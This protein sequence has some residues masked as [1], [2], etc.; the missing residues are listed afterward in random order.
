VKA[1]RNLSPEKRNALVFLL[2]FLLG[3]IATL[4]SLRPQTSYVTELWEQMHGEQG[5]SHKIAFSP[6]GE[7]L[8]T[9]AQTVKVWRAKD[10]K[11]VKSFPFN[12]P[13]AV[14]TLAPNGKWLAAYDVNGTVKVWKLP[15]GKIVKSLKADRG[16]S[17]FLAFSPDGEFLA[18]AS[19]ELGVVKVWRVESGELVKSLSLGANR[20]V[21]MAVSPGGEFLAVMTFRSLNLDDRL[22]L[23]HLPATKKISIIRAPIS[24]FSFSPDG[25]FLTSVGVGSE[26]YVVALRKVGDEE[27]CWKICFPNEVTMVKFHPCDSSILFVYE[28]TS[29]DLLAPLRPQPFTTPA[30]WV[31]GDV[32]SYWRLTKGGLEKLW[33][34]RNLVSKPLSF[35]DPISAL[36]FSP[37]G[38]LMAVVTVGSRVKVFRLNVTFEGGK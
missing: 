18:T 31:Y 4:F 7:F 1:L 35:T 8:I 5:Y 27:P 26:G 6:D 13:D 37:D 25:K 3:T 17:L 28:D 19:H 16:R 23:W 30:F 24:Q 2:I 21:N 12:P 22:E 38:K 32:L 15:E 29:R 34:A 20:V 9:A 36:A 10:G 14:K 11:L 33:E